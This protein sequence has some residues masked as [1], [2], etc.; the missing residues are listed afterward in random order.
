M[1][2][3]IDNSKSTNKLI[4]KIFAIFWIVDGLLQLQPRLLS[5][6]FIDKVINPLFINNHT[7]LQLAAS[8]LSHIF[9]LQPLLFGLLIALIQI[10]IGIMVFSNR[11]RRI[12]LVISVLWS[13][14]I[15][16][17]GQN[18]GGI[19]SHQINPLQS[20]PG[21]AVFY[22]LISI[23]FLLSQNKHELITYLVLFFSWSLFWLVQMFT[24]LI[25]P[26]L[27]RMGIMMKL[28]N[29]IP[30][31][32]LSLNRSIQNFSLSHI[33]L[34]ILLLLFIPLIAI[35]SVFFNRK[36]NI[37]ISPIWIS[38]LI[39][40]FV[41]FQNLGSYYTGLMTDIGIMP[42]IIF[43]GFQLF[44]SG[45]NFNLIVNKLEKKLF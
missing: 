26:G 13:L 17:F 6:D 22:T 21:P 36:F 10:T 41:Y 19:F 15:W 7:V 25:N 23:Y 24:I 42:I 35:L 43:I 3:I 38:Y 40:I 18:A 14:F 20:S 45:K 2:R 8:R 16:L 37:Y 11:Y 31:Y 32:L 12:G 34:V 30:S 9:L 4:I 39:F 1:D 28:N 5:K 27:I 44:D 33:N 29:N